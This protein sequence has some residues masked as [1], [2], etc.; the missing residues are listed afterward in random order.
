MDTYPIPPQLWLQ[1]ALQTS[2]VGLAQVPWL[3][4]W[5]RSISWVAVCVAVQG[6]LVAALD[7]PSPNSQI[8]KASAPIT[9][10]GPTHCCSKIRPRA[11]LH[12][13]EPILRGSME[14]GM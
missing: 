1:N 9:R 3:R 8:R 10:E 12:G 4:V 7:P 6:C 2:L 13:I 5:C 14:T 11:Q